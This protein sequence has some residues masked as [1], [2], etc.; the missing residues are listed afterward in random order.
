MFDKKRM[1]V[2]D[3]EIN[4]RTITR[5]IID[6]QLLDLEDGEKIYLMINSPGG[7][8]DALKLLM[9]TIKNLDSELTTVCIGAA[10]SSAAILFLQGTE[11]IMLKGTK[12]MFHYSG[13]KGDS[14]TSLPIE[15]LSIHCDSMK[16]YNESILEE[17]LKKSNLKKEDLEKELKGKKYD[18]SEKK[19]LENGLATKSIKNFKEI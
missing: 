13:L 6:L 12:L 18:V 8:I 16:E 17:I 1:V 2:L 3:K 10:E 11:R 5:L 15:E 14:G 7:D 9:Q 19:A 4:F